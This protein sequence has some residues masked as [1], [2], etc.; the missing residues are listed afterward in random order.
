MR[1]RPAARSPGPRVPTNFLGLPATLVGMTQEPDSSRY[2]ARDVAVRRTR[3]I[4]VGVAAGAVALSG[5]GSFLAARAFKGHTTS[6]VT[7]APTDSTALAR[8]PGPQAVPPI[9]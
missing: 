7:P 2:R 6:S 9:A 1:R 5:A 3:A 4:V 8:V